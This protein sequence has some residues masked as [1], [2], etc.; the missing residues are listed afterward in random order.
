MDSTKRLQNP[1][2]RVALSYL[3]VAVLWIVFSDALLD[4]FGLSGSIHSSISILKGIG[5]VLVTATVLYVHLRGEFNLRSRLENSLQEQI[6]RIQQAQG[7]L[8][9]SESHFRKA[10]EEAP[11]PIIIFAEDGEVLSVSQTWLDITG[12]THAQLKHIDS[13]TELAYGERQQAIR[14]VIDRLFTL[15]RRVDEGEFVIRCA[16]GDRRIWE[17][18]ST[19]LGQLSDGRRIVISIAADITARK[20]LEDDLQKFAD[21]CQHAETG[22]AVGY[23]NSPNLEWVNPAFAHMH[24]YT[25]EEL[26]GL[27]ITSVFVPE[28]L[29]KLAE[30]VRLS[31]ERGHHISEA[32]HRC[33]DGESFPV[34]ID[35]TAVKD[36]SGDVKYRIITVLDIT[37][38]KRLQDEIHLQSQFL[39]M[40]I[41]SSPLGI[42]SFD[43]EG[44]V[45]LWNP[46]M[47]ELMGWSQ[48]EVIGQTMPDFRDL[49]AK[50]QIEF[51]EL[52]R[53]ITSGETIKGI[54]I[55]YPRKDG[56]F[57]DLSISAGPLYNL[58]GEFV[59]VIAVLQDITERKRME[60]ALRE[61]ELR[62][63]QLAEHIRD[64]FFLNEAGNRQLL[65][66]SSAY[67]TIWGRSCESLYENPLSF[68]EAVHP[69]DRELV[70][71]AFDRQRQGEQVTVLYRIVR[72]DHTI[73]W[74]RSRAFPVLEESGA[75]HRIAGIAED[76]TEQVQYENNLKRLSQRLVTVLDEERARIARELHD[77]IGQEMTAMGINL[78]IIEMHTHSIPAVIPIIEE[79]SEL[80]ST[81]IQRIR[82]IV[83]DLRPVA[84]DD[85]GLPAALRWYSER[86]SRRT[87]ILVNLQNDLDMENLGPAVNN[88]LYQIATEALINVAKHAQARHVW[89]AL[90]M[91]DHRLTFSIRDD[92][93]GFDVEEVLSNKYR[94]H[95]GI[96]IMQERIN[97][98]IGSRIHLDSSPGQGTQV[99]VKVEL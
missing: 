81:V 97:A 23:P 15:D 24:G 44:V 28:D 86:F 83:A 84:L 14:D 46:S 94:S 3:A 51:A 85:M 9:Q 30:I 62:F 56:H 79:S 49:Q 4:F 37:E 52:N 48:D 57:I 59:G 64:V 55:Q 58:H 95:W 75:L 16:N 69:D 63:R 65:Y 66:I 25:V 89:I 7:E 78:G 21:I 87:G 96:Q 43:M 18:S 20:K 88:T 93:I 50:D 68:L 92:G 19:P 54:D 67:E 40:L 77:Q 41:Q 1:S 22:I 10:V 47:Q 32:R 91:N 13:W 34:V 26:M 38:Q 76:I 27:P 2:T 53:R 71:S 82:S 35:A 60:S 80:V 11:L 5:F 72:P 90:E 99:L 73:R 31:H 98:L 12:Y 61:S 29:P 33:K 74:I 6:V 45:T 8:A 17:F 36:E 70:V 42:V 39:S